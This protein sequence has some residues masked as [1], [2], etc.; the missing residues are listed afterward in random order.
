MELLAVLSCAS[1]SLLPEQYVKG[2]EDGSL[3]RELEGLEL[4][5]GE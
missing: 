2:V 1:R 5:V 3:A 4:R